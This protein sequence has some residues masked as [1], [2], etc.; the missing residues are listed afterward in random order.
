MGG[1][2][3]AAGH[4]RPSQRDVGQRRA[5]VQRQIRNAALIGQYVLMLLV[6]IVRHGTRLLKQQQQQQQQSVK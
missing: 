5:G 6:V 3:A 1:Y 2:R 4:G